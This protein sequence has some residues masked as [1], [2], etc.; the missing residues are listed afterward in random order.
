MIDKSALMIEKQRDWL[1]RYCYDIILLEENQ[2]V[3]EVIRGMLLTRV[4]YLTRDNKELRDKLGERTLQH[5]TQLDNAVR[6]LGENKELK[7]KLTLATHSRY[8]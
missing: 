1:Q 3:S 7:D 6:L 2:E 4:A 8:G 5:K